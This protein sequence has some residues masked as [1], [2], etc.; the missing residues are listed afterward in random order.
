MTEPSG[1]A[2]PLGPITARAAVRRGLLVVNFPVLAI[3]LAGCL[4][5]RTLDRGRFITTC[6]L[7][8]ALIAAWAYWSF[9][10][11][12]WRRWALER[13]APAD[14]LQRLAVA[15]GLVWPKGWF[16]EKTEFKLRPP[17]DS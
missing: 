3:I 11:P 9:S 5:T 1:D 13:G 16:P 7:G 4:A 8:G 6:L 12:R 15:A 2:K 17:R 10:V 14:E